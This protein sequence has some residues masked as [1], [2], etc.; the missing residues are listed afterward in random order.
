MLV[1]FRGRYPPGGPVI[2][3][4]EFERLG[5]QCASPNTPHGMNNFRSISPLY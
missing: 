3:R 4:E 2:V 5:F 1:K